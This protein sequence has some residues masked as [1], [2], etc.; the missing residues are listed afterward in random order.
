MTYVWGEYKDLYKERKSLNEE[1]VLSEKA[2]A[3]AA[4]ALVERKA[5]TEKREFILQQLEAQSKG[6]LAA[7]Q[8]RAAQFEAA[9]GQ[10]QQ[11]RS[12]VDSGQL[13]KEAEEK[14]QRLMSEF[15]GLGVNLN[16]PLRCDDTA[17]VARF[18]IAKAKYTEAYTLAEAYGLTKKYSNFF[19][20][21]GQHIY[22]ACQK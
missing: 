14:I 17:G 5:E 10:L 22:S 1:I 3:E 7:V 21:T 15:S 11:A 4:I 12:T 19:F 18:N 8:Q 2:R 6:Q 20:H 16:D 13:Q 9:A